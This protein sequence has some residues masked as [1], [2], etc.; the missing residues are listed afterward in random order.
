MRRLPYYKD[1]KDIKT[2]YK[3]KCDNS[4]T[5]IIDY[6]IINN[7]LYYLRYYYTN[8]KMIKIDFKTFEHNIILNIDSNNLMFTTSVLTEKGIYV[9]DKENNVNFI[10]ITKYINNENDSS[11][12][13]SSIFN[14]SDIE[15]LNHTCKIKK[16]L[17]SNDKIY[18][19]SI[20]HK[21]L[22]VDYNYIH[23]HN[24]L[25][26]EYDII[27]TVNLIYDRK[28]KKH[29]ID[30][31]N[32]YIHANT[33]SL[34]INYIND[35]FIIS[36]HNYVITC[37]KNEILS[38][39]YYYYM[40]FVSNSKIAFKY[41]NNVII[42]DVID[43]SIYFLNEQL[44]DYFHHFRLINNEYILIHDFINYV[45]IK[46]DLD[47][48]LDNN[49]KYKE[50]YTNLIKLNYNGLHIDESLEIIKKLL[51]NNTNDIENDIFLSILLKKYNY[52][53]I[54]NNIDKIYG[55]DS[56]IYKELIIFSLKELNN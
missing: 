54:L 45:L 47:G 51:E 10:N 16:I 21:N 56:I 52:N 28:N 24:I 55:N 41:H 33:M 19:I 12:N 26:D 8:L 23:I 42:Y 6:E 5:Y 32:L 1:L 3:E 2:V 7:N 20:T 15:K 46:V 11:F 34:K 37:N 18:Y 31:N 49:S 39:N 25:N 36:E 9:I 22:E 4:F 17:K 13:F 27:F 14:C 43:K 53:D 30:D 44:W 48:E 38:S 29:Y 35:V 40:T 50:I